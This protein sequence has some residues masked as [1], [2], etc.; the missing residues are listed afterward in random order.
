MIKE[1]I[2]VVVFSLYS[3]GDM[4]YLGETRVETRV[5]SMAICE[6][7]K[8]THYS[9]NFSANEEEDWREGMR[10]TIFCNPASL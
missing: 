8:L 6:Q 10:V 3:P 7:M 4:E 9:T 5:P 2:F 1:A